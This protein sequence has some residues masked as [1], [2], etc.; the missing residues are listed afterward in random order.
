MFDFRYHAL[1]LVAVFLALTIGLLLGVVIGDQGLVSSAE[2]DIRA[3]LRKDVE[4][5]RVEADR[6][7]R[8]IAQH[9]RFEDEAYPAIVGGRLDGEKIG[10]VG[11]GG[12]SDR[13]VR[14]VR[15]SLDQTGGRL[16]SVAVIRE[17]LE[18]ESI[19]QQAKGTRY[20]ELAKRP[21]LVEAFGRRM[22]EQ[23]ATS[24]KLIRR[25]KSPL[26]RSSS[27]EL[28]DLDGVVVTRTRANPKGDAGVVAENFEKGFIKGLESAGVEVVGVEN[29][30]SRPSQIN[31]FKQ[32]GITSV[33]NVN[34]LAGRAALVLSLAGAEGTFGTKAS[35]DTLLPRAVGAANSR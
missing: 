28:T 19:G 33:D 20:E 35:A 30:F 18:L 6:A 32:Q 2:R 23:Y 12:L 24:G 22:G 21:E 11:F 9:E 10:L 14:S 29:T 5:A 15:S 25:V 17:P 3:S 31:W 4:E 13:T 16:V 8:K 27:G 26:L 34:Q 1:T 7:N